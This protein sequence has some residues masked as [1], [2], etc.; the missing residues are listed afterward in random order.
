LGGF[1]RRVSTVAIEDD[2]LFAPSKFFR[3]QAER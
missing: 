2:P 3:I 1:D